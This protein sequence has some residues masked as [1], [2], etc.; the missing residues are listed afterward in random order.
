MI[1]S[2]RIMNACVIF[3]DLCYN[4][5]NKNLIFQSYD[6]ASNISGQYDGAQRGLS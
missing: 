3:M 5:P 6:F 2:I 1:I 4:K